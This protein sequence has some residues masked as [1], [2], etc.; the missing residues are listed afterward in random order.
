MTRGLPRR[1]GGGLSPR[2]TA[3]PGRHTPPAW[4]AARTTSRHLDSPAMAFRDL[5]D[6]LE[7]LRRAGELHEV[8]AQV[9]PHL[10]ISEIS[11]RLVKAGGGPGLLFRKVKG[12]GEPPLVKQFAEGR[13]GG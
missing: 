10:E 2:P 7:H 1:D 12:P 3:R 4:P 9:D 6:W 8:T 11:D 13:G 5:R